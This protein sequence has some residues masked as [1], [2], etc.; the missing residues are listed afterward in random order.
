[1]H[2]AGQALEDGRAVSFVT[3]TPHERLS[4]S[5]T[6]LVL[7]HAWDMLRKRMTRTSPNVDY[8]LVPE[9]HKSG[10]LHLHGLFIDAPLKRKWWK[11]NAR[12][13]G[14][15]YQADMKEV[16]RVGGVAA[17]VGKYI[18]K[19][20]QNSNLP[21]RFHRVRVSSGFP[22]LPTAQAGEDWEVT[23]LQPSQNLQAVIQSW[24][25]LGY[26]IVLTDSANAWSA[27]ELFGVPTEKEEGE[28]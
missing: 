23:V 19:T 1:V 26:G 16:E 10:K 2:G 14:F 20:L 9:P 27:F 17:Y 3:I 13:C 22:H 8:M 15:G 7:P 11:D 5:T 24:K 21:K 12:A 28:E 6:S 18:G 25:D 4:A